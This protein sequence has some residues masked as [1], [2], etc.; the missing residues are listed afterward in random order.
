[1]KIPQEYFQVFR[2]FK[3]QPKNTRIANFPQQT[4][5]GWAKYQ[6]G[7]SG[8]G[9]LWYGIEQPILDRAFD[10]WS[11]KNENYYWEISYALYSKNLA[12][13]EK[14]LEKYQINWLLVD[15]NIINPSSPNA[16]YFDELGEMISKSA[17]ISLAQ[18]FNKIKI[19]Q[20]NLETP[21][22]DF[23]FLTENLPQ[24]EPKYNWNNYDQAFLDNRNYSSL[25]GNWKLEIGN[26]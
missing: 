15:G 23:V 21:V 25:I 24:I 19:Y 13:F 17:K 8:S 16:L 1:L 14:V 12:L 10:V 18:E 26:S 9:F 11:D 20:V 7:Y 22:K 6:W 4:Y 5:W 2:F 3:Q